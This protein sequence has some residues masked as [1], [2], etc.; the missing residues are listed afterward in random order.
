MIEELRLEQ[1]NAEHACP[2]GAMIRR[3]G[4][5]GRSHRPYA[6]WFC[7][8]EACPPEWADL[9]EVIGAALTDWAMGK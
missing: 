3:A 8:D 1:L 2:H 9:A 5:G 4:I 7:P 6:G